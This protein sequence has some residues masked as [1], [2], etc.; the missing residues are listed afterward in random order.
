MRVPLQGG[1]PELVAWGFRNPYG[2]AFNSKDQ[3]FITDN[4]YD[5]RGSRPVWGTGD[6]LWKINQGQWYGWPDYSGGHEINTRHFKVPDKGIPPKVLA[7]DPNKPPHPAARLGVHSSSNGFDFS[8][9]EYF[10]FKDEAFVAQFGDMAPGVGKVYKPVGY[11]V[12]RVNT[13]TGVIYTF[14]VNKK[15]NLPA[16]K[17]NSGGIE[18]PVAVRFSP[19]GNSLYIVDYGIMLTSEE[20]PKPIEETGVIWKIS[21]QEK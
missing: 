12:V 4:G 17:L 6:Y 14:A 19:D 16:S 13:E 7:E 1:E 8:R 9:S 2:L 11:K 10:G 21:K 15:D 5:D 3:L 20:G 18:R